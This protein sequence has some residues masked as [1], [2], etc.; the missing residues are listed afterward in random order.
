MLGMETTAGWQSGG[1]EAASTTA[2]EAVLCGAGRHSRRLCLRLGSLGR[3]FGGYRVSVGWM[4]RAK[5]LAGMLA[6]ADGGDTLERRSPR[7]GVIFKLH[8]TW[9]SG[10]KPSP[11]R[12]VRRWRF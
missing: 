10:R 1:D 2:E 11:F 3:G 12:D 6:G 8:P 9:F 4:L 5:A 7:W